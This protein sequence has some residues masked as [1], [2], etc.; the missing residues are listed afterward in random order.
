MAVSADT[1]RVVVRYQDGRVLK[2]VTHDFFPAKPTFHVE[3]DSSSGPP[4]TVD[5]ATLK[6]IFFV[7]SYE[8][9]P[10]HVEDLSFDNAR[11]QGRKIN[12]TFADGEVIAG[13]TMGYNPTK[14]GF[15]VFPTDAESNNAR[16]FVVSAAVTKVEWV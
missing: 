14:P 6:A 3:A 15:W 2:G 1:N 7:K 10:Q 12:V 4:L 13:F 5:V 8:G 11:G 9:D 16:I